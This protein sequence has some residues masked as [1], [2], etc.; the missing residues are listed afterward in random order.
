MKIACPST[1]S[2]V[3]K[4]MAIWY[5]SNHSTMQFCSC[6][7]LRQHRREESRICRHKPALLVCFRVKRQCALTEEAL[8]LLQRLKCY[9][10]PAGRMP[11]AREIAE[12]CAS[13]LVRRDDGEPV[14]EA[15]DA[16]SILAV[17]RDIER[18]LIAIGSSPDPELAEAVEIV[19]GTFLDARL[20]KI[21]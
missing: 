11:A 16:A 8:A 3:I 14:S 4:K 10:V 7:G 20:V 17:L 18:E 12:R 15:D 13:W 9:T 6:G 19:Q 5:G 21:Q 2:P 1:P